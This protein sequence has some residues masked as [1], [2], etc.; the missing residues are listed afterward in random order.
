ME[1]LSSSAVD[2]MEEYTSQSLESESVGTSLSQDDI[3][4]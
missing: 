4:D 3:E 1:E 2:D